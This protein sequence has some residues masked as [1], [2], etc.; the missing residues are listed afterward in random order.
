M[1]FNFFL[2]ISILLLLQ[3]CSNIEKPHIFTKKI[4]IPTLTSSIDKDNDNIDDYTDIV[5][6]ARSQ[7]GI[8]TEYD[9][10]YYG[11]GGYPPE[12][13][14]LAQTLYGELF[15]QQVTT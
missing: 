12:I 13:K 7:I 5:E 4:E 9:T 11:N 6:S 8:V 14:E 10:Q 2:L 15:Y 3:G 1:K